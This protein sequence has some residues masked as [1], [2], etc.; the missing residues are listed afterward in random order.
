M[1]WDVICYAQVSLDAD[2]EGGLDGNYEESQEPP[3]ELLSLTFQNDYS[4]RQIK[5]ESQ[6]DSETEESRYSLEDESSLAHSLAFPT[7]V[8]SPS[9]YFSNRSPVTSSNVPDDSNVFCASSDKRTYNEVET[10]LDY[11]DEFDIF[12]K[13]VGVQLKQLPLENA[14]EMQAK[15]HQLLI[16]ERLKV[17]RQNKR[18]G[19]VIE[20]DESEVNV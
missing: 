4:N 7:D 18:N 12:G 3:H 16:D 5:E 8:R 15:I 9:S 14:L 2:D 19:L 11:T 1:I 6:D 17:I 10:T 13:N 20:N